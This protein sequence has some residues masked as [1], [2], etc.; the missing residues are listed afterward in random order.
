[1]ERGQHARRLLESSFFMEIV[2]HLTTYHMAGMAACRPGYKAD[3]DALAYHH[4]MQHA[5]TEIAGTLKQFVE[6]GDAEAAL[7]VRDNA[8]NGDPLA[9]A[10]HE[11]ST[12]DDD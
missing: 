3:A 8:E 9:Q 7:L 4:T 10:L 6:A 11:L 2:D 1:M 12:E 5:I